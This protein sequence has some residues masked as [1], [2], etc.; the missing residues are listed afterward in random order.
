MCV[1]KE[2]IVFLFFFLI[3]F[4]YVRDPH[5]LD[6]VIFKDFLFY[7][8]NKFI[9]NRIKIID[10]LSQ[11]LFYGLCLTTFYRLGHYQE[12]SSIIIQ[13]IVA[14]FLVFLQCLHFKVESKSSLK[15]RKRQTALC[16]VVDGIQ[17]PGGAFIL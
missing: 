17:R 15:I 13:K 1:N 9:H 7:L 3:N 12:L 11:I 2:Y 10:N 6:F 14:C 8:S 16:S 5:G 4:N